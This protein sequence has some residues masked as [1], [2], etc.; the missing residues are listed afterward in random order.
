MPL[1]TKVGGC[2]PD[3]LGLGD[4]LPSVPL[5]GA[6]VMLSVGIDVPV[7][8]ILGSNVAVSAIVGTRV[9]FALGTVGAGEVLDESSRTVGERVPSVEGEVV[10]DVGGDGLPAMVGATVELVEGVPGAKL[11][12]D[13]VDGVLP[14]A[15]VALEEGVV[16]AVGVLPGAS[17]AFDDGVEGAVGA[18]AGASVELPGRPS[19]P[20]PVPVTFNVTKFSSANT[21]SGMLPVRPTL[22]C[23]SR[24]SRRSN[25]PNSVGMDP[26]KKF[27][28]NNIAVSVVIDPISVGNVPSTKLVSRLK[29][30]SAVKELTSVGMGPVNSHEAMW[31]FLRLTSFAKSIA[32]NGMNN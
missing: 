15:S 26:V 3:P 24:I 30:S 32:G 20:I 5:V 31:R 25:K 14:G 29:T 23:N 28:P 16:G 11:G 7:V 17:V 19:D 4:S 13:V 18:P 6:R 1:P 9:P 21:S 10:D 12:A 22:S 2:V 8:V 27:A